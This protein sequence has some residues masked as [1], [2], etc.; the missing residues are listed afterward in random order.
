[1]KR[2]VSF[3]RASRAAARPPLGWAAACLCVALAALLVPDA[4]LFAAGD[5]R[6]E[7]MQLALEMLGVMVAVMVVFGAYHSLDE[8][9]RP[10]TNILV[11]A[12]T[13]VAGIGFVH[14]VSHHAAPTFLS[15]GSLSSAAFFWRSERVIE[16]FGFVLMLS[17][18]RLHAGRRRSLLLGLAG[19]GLVVLMWEIGSTRIPR[20]LVQGFADHS[21]RALADATLSVA[22]LLLAVG[23]WRAPG[24]AVRLDRKSLTMACVALAASQ[25]AM[26]GHPG[27]GPLS[28]GLGHILRI[29]G[30]GYL[31]HSILLVALRSPFETLAASRRLLLQKER[32]YLSLIEH[33]PVG[34]LRLDTE[35]NVNLVSAL[36]QHSLGRPVPSMMGRPVAEVLPE[37]VMEVLRPVFRSV[38]D[39]HWQE[40][41]YDYLSPTQGRLYRH[42]I[43]APEYDVDGNLQGILGIILDVT[44]RR[45]SALRLQAITQE[46]ED[47]RTAI[48][49]HAIVAITDRRGVIQ[50]VNQ[51]FCDISRYAEDEL[52]GNTHRIINSGHHPKSFFKEMWRT[53]GR[54][55]VWSGE[56]CN[57]AKDGSI[58]W[59]QTTIVPLLGKDQ[60]PE[61]YIAIRADITQRKLAEQEVERLAF[62]DVLT[63]LPNRRML[64]RQLAQHLGRKDAA[65][66][67]G[68]L[69]LLDLDHFKDI[70]DTRGH[71]Q[72]DALLR[73]VGARLIECVRDIDRIA[74]LGGDEF[75]VLLCHLGSS[76]QAALE[77]AADLGE[78]IRERLSRPFLLEGETVMSSASLGAVLF[79]S[80]GVVAPEDLL[81]RADLA[82]YKA[83]EDGRN[84]LRFFNPE[85]QSE[86]NE[87]ME[88][89]RDLRLALHRQELR[90]FYQPIVDAAGSVVG[91]EALVRWQHP[92][93]GLVSPAVF[94]PLSEQ[95]GL[96]VDIGRWVLETACRQLCLWADDPQRAEWT[97]SVNIS[98]RQ[99]HEPGFIETVRAALQ[100]TG[101]R[102]ERLKLELTE[103]MLLADIDDSI[104]KII[105]LE[106]MGVQFSL[107]D[108]G[109]GYSPLSYLRRLPLDQCKIDAS[110]VR[111][112]LTDE[113]S[114]AIVRMILT[115]AANLG[116]EV[117]A[118]GVETRE[119]FELLRSYGC[120]YFQ[121]YLFGRPA[122]LPQE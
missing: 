66:T 39:G 14:A 18:A 104:S 25:L 67:Y 19:A 89:L 42:F 1:M 49:A 36:L 57:R 112:I 64:M 74:R 62:Y 31:I 72:G 11:M 8:A 50:Y 28:I 2:S 94:I 105:A 32:E 69:I 96:I 75:V 55:E 63:G 116:L 111:D 107:D 117:V 115:L 22:Y 90:L 68:A 17:P 92:E 119:Q 85:F 3:A 73:Q 106:S 91:V 10:V 102:A 78:V 13:A 58:Y 53:I 99:L 87:R 44:E 29:V 43:A 35:L 83:K 9:R 30:Y 65:P 82:L 120:R 34:V 21:T 121:G 5:S 95:S 113:D 97:V 38:L 40:V 122:P 71:L 109:T 76:R 88:L 110:F 46:A 15:P 118:E 100:Q 54:G 47:L 77:I 56:L 37:E 86:V 114:A 48:N 79:K 24:A 52:I 6:L 98:A 81:Q 26:L 70:N 7:A 45:K 84:L 108:F 23:F 20:L 16:L 41:D 51:K 103:N 12:F 93:R 27:S 59:V 33:L 80:D 60:R 101:A 61:R 4:M